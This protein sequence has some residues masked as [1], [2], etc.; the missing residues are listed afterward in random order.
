MSREYDIYLRQHKAN[1]AK[2][3]AWIKENLPDIIPDDIRLNLEHQCC[4]AHDTSKTQQDEYEPYDKYFYGG[5]RSYEAVQDFNY[6]W[7]LHIHRNPHHW[8]H[9]ILL[10]DEPDEGEIVLDMPYQYIIEMI[11]DWWSFSWN[12]GDLYE[13][14]N[15][16]DERK[17]YIKL[18]KKSRVTVEDILM[19]IHYKLDELKE[20]KPNE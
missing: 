10:N 8:H 18:S 9:W 14:F 1:V 4:F 17:D 3:Y 16:Y 5:N 15:W 6:A 11:C 12:K 19:Q 7:L 2:G 13:I 20:D